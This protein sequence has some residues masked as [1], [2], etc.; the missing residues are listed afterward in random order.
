MSGTP[1][2]I[3]QYT[4]QEAADKLR[5]SKRHVEKMCQR[6]ELSSIGTGRLRRIRAVD[7]AAWQQQN[8]NGGLN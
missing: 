7:L 6:G 8:R 1:D 2:P 4:L 3:Q 5:Y